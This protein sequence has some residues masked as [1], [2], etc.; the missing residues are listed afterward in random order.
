MNEIAES[1]NT[2]TNAI[3]EGANGVNGAAESTQVLVVDMDKINRRMEDN[4]RIASD[5]QK[6][7]DVF[8][9]F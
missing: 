1:I 5:L 7:T 4:Q 9:I 6:G 8:K 3:D 2:I